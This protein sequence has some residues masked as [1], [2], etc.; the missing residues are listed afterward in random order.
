M[1]LPTKRT[2]GTPALTT[3]FLGAILLLLSVA[4]VSERWHTWSP[5]RTNAALTFGLLVCGAINLAATWLVLRRHV[6]AN[7]IYLAAWV[8]NVAGWVALGVASS[9]RPLWWVLGIAVCVGY[10]GIVLIR[11]LR[12]HSGQASRAA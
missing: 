9:R 11:Q 8:L 3:L 5:S 2:F 1:A 10:L 7:F 12:I 6:L 4:S